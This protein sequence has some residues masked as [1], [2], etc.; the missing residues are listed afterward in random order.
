MQEL[1]PIVTIEDI[2]AKVYV[3]LIEDVVL[4]PALVQSKADRTYPH[5]YD[6]SDPDLQDSYQR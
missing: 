5:P 2:R 3:K 1:L 6:P 4:V